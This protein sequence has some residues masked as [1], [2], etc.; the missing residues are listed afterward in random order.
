MTSFQ[1]HRLDQGVLT[2]L[3]S[4]TLC[5]ELQKHVFTNCSFVFST[6][7]N[8]PDGSL[9]KELQETNLILTVQPAQ[10]L[11]REDSTARGEAELVTVSGNSPGQLDQRG[12]RQTEADTRTMRWGSSDGCG[13]SGA[14][15]TPDSRKSVFVTEG[16]NGSKQG[17]VVKGVRN[18]ASLP[19]IMKLSSS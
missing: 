19:K 6:Y 16:M 2:P 14:L 9:K 13:K 1:F 12:G 5:S 3:C 15:D 17:L 7:L 18:Q 4:S 11:E 10:Q 8:P